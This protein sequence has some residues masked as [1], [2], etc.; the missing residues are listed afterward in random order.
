MLVEFDQH[1][2]RQAADADAPNPREPPKAAD[3]PLPEFGVALESTDPDTRTREQP[4][5]LKQDGRIVAASLYA[6]TGI[7]AGLLC[8]PTMRQSRNGCLVLD[9]R[10]KLRRLAIRL[11]KL[12]QDIPR[13]RAGSHPLHAR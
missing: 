3:Q 8:A 4:A 9:A 5:A 12:D 10:E 2:P 6:A 7:S 13:H 1:P 11:I